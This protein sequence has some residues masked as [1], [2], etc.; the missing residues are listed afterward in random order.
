MAYVSRQSVFVQDL[1]ILRSSEGLRTPYN[2]YMTDQ[3]ISLNADNRK[4]IPAGM[5]VVR[6]GTVDRYLPR[7]RATAAFSTGAT[8]GTITPYNIFAVGEV[9]TTVFPYG[10][11]TIGGTYLATERVAITVGTRRV[12]TVTGSTVN[13]TIATTVAAALNNDPIVSKLVSTVVSG[14][15][16]HFYS[17]DGVTGHALVAE[18]RN[19]A[20]SGASAAGT[21]TA[22]GSNLAIGTVGTIASIASATGVITLTANAGVNVPI[23][24]IVGINFGRL[25]G[26]DIRSRDFTDVPNNLFAPYYEGSVYE[27]NLPYIDEQIK[28][29]LNG[30]QFSV[31]Y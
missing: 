19:A 14:A 24:G 20:D 5:F 13:A 1:P 15:V 17:K 21:A 4:A 3:Y 12:S 18:A 31:K 2:A 25:I 9:L 28:L 11:V 22:S 6:S 27:G 26:V 29:E 8:T 7:A 23:G 10:S 16:L 30:M